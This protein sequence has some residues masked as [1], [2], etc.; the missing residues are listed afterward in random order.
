MGFA[1]FTISELCLFIINSLIK[2]KDD[3]KKRIVAG[4]MFFIMFVFAFILLLSYHSFIACIFLYF[5][6]QCIKDCRKRHMD[7][8]SCRL[9]SLSAPHPHQQHLEPDR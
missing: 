1:L 6:R 4:L 7:P 2:F 3:K 8:C 5:S 9:A